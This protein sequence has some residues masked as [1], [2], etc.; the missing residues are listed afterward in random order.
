VQIVTENYLRLYIL[1]TVCL[2][3]IT[4][5]VAP[6]EEAIIDFIST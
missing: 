5:G 1:V 3:V 4:D 6:V 2:F